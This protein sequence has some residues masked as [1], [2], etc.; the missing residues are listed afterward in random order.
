[1]LKSVQ[2]VCGAALGLAGC[3]G[4]APLLHPVHPLAPE[5]VAMGAGVSTQIVAGDA[6][7]V[8]D[9]AREAMSDG[10]IDSNAERHRFVKG[11]LAYSLLAPGLAPWVGARVGI[12]H[13]A[14]A[15]VT[16][17]AR[18][19]R[20]DGRYALTDDAFA[21]SGGLGASGV[22]AR[23]GSDP[24]GEFRGDRDEKIPGLDLGGVSGFGMDLPLLAGWRSPSN[25]WQVWLGA[26]GGFERLRGTAALHV[27]VDPSVSDEARFEA[28]RWYAL[29][30]VGFGVSLHPV[31][32]ALEI[33]AGYQHGSG[34]V[35]LDS[36]RQDG[37]LDGISVTPGL[38]VI[39]NLWK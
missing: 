28:S 23:P 27:D 4:G 5:H 11:A 24:P 31:T 38:A 1:M 33:D 29:G 34:L 12:G 2:I 6:A 22:L 20:I 14:E 39:L 35:M 7:A 32:V 9:D 26:R 10:A 19:V 16:Y 37:S 18:A 21:L 13:S 8:I 3:G 25:L 30:V 15:G 17:T 36:G